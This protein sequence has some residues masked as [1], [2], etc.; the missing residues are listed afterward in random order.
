V[1]D[2]LNFVAH[3]HVHGEGAG[4]HLD[5]DSS[6]PNLDPTGIACLVEAE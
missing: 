6:P 1:N 5:S 3:T 4:N 2:R